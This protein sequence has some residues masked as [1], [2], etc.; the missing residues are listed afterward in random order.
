MTRNYWIEKNTG[1]EWYIG[2]R[3]NTEL[4]SR[5]FAKNS[6]IIIIIDL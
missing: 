5:I 6:I 1:M 2:M 4:I 3:W